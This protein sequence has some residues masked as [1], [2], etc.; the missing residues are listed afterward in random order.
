MAQLVPR[1]IQ[2]PDK[3]PEEHLSA[4]DKHLVLNL[5]VKNPLFKVFSLYANLFFSIPFFNCFFFT[6]IN[7]SNSRRSS[8]FTAGR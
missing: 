2:D 3:P 8:F 1:A 7:F 6:D 5:K 4:V